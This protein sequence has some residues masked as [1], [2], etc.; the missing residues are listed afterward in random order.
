MYYKTPIY[1][2]KQGNTGLSIN[3]YGDPSTS[4]HEKYLLWWLHCAV[5]FLSSCTPA[6]AP[7]ICIPITACCNDHTVL[8]LQNSG[9][10]KTWPFLLVDL[11]NRAWT[12]AA[13]FFKNVKAFFGSKIRLL[14]K[15]AHT[16]THT[17]RSAQCCRVSEA[18]PWL[19]WFIHSW[20]Q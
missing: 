6:V 12:W 10:T 9:S 7:Y 3:Y 2:Q 4:D 16:S 5:A 17:Y 11:N 15:L 14:W 20:Q 8:T 13:F 19:I 18:A 1:L